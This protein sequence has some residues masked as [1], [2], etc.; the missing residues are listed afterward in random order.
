MK[1]YDV[2]FTINTKSVNAGEY[3]AP[4]NKKKTIRQTIKV[5][6]I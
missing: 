1:R 5:L 3:T 6:D 4:P 2:F